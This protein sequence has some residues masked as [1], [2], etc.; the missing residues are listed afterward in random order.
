MRQGE[1]TSQP[2]ATE[3]EEGGDGGGAPPLARDYSGRESKERSPSQRIR[4]WILS[5]RARGGW[6]GPPSEEA[7]VLIPRKGGAGAFVRSDR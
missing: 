7:R 2:S 4:G 6:R 5:R 3:R 1:R